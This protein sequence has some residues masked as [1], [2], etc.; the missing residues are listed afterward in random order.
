M[1]EEVKLNVPG[2]LRKGVKKGSQLDSVL[3]GLR[4]LEYIQE[5][6]GLDS[7]SDVD[8]LDYGCGVKFSQAIIQY[9]LEVKSYTGFDIDMKMI[10][11]LVENNSDT[12]FS[13][14]TVPFYN[15]LYNKSGEKMTKDYALPQLDH[16]VDLVTMQSVLTHFHPHDFE[17]CLS[18]L[19]RYL[20]DKGKIFFTFIGHIDAD[21]P[22]KNLNPERPLLRASY[23]LDHAKELVSIAGLKIDFFQRR[24]RLP[25]IPEHIVCSK[26]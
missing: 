22:F 17:V 18:M 23:D 13:Y 1:I 11:Y 6:C 3:S 4:T 12:R 10:D 20:K 16:K 8:I 24:C 15:K 25:Y 14:Q 19:R 21:V 5:I 26:K 7:L 9:D 2:N